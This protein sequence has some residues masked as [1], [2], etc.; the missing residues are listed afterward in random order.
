MTT[1]P[2]CRIAIADSPELAGQWLA[3]PR[4][5]AQFQMPGAATI[6]APPVIESPEP[7]P[8]PLEPPPLPF[9]AHPTIQ[10]ARAVGSSAARNWIDQRRLGND[11]PY[12]IKVA[13][14]ALTAVWILG[15]V[16]FFFLLLTSGFAS[17]DHDYGSIVIVEGR[18]YDAG[19]YRAGVF[20][21]AFGWGLCCPT[22]PYVMTMAL[23]GMALLVAKKPD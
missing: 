17:I 15:C 21:G 19:A 10:A 12:T 14:L 9:H 2:N 13:M 8:L 20:I 16:G 1:C 6:E 23:L 4:C 18:D 5:G 22:V 7:P 3:C 11:W